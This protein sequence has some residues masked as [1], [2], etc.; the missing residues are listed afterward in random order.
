M[1]PAA[2]ALHEALSK[3]KFHDPVKP[4]IANVNAMMYDGAGSIVPNLLGQLVGPVLWQ[5][6]VEYLLEQGFERF[7]ELGPGR[8]LTGLV[9][10][11]M[12]KAKKK[13][14]II[15]INGLAK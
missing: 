2:D 8:V 9:K 13:V 14:E 1:Q 4:V 10:K 15:T 3:S 5:Q 11:T 12:R 7:I 6:S